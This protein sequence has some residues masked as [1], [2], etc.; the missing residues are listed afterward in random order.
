MIC[1]CESWND[2]KRHYSTRRQILYLAFTIAN[3]MS[4]HQVACINNTLYIIAIHGLARQE[5][6]CSSVDKAPN[7][8]PGGHMF[9]SCV[10]Q[11][12]CCHTL[13]KMNTSFYDTLCI[14]CPLTDRCHILCSGRDVYLHQWSVYRLSRNMPTS[15]SY[16]WHRYG[17]L[18]WSLWKHMGEQNARD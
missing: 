18:G 17:R 4:L 12:F 2:W 1:P 6:P 7:R 13:V 9:E 14:T 16:I 15:L 10:S 11:I 3:T 8:Y 5:S